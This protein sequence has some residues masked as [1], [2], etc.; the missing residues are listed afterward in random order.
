MTDSQ[1]LEDRIDEAA[2]R[3][4]SRWTAILSENAAAEK[5]WMA[6]FGK[7]LVGEAPYGDPDDDVA[8]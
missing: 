7:P 4:A 1:T 3:L 5:G 8:L 6:A 2:A